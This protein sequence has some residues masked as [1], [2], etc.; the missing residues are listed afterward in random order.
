METF[1]HFVNVIL[2]DIRFNQG[3]RVIAVN[4]LSVTD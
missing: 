1:Q 3:R 4:Q 2:N